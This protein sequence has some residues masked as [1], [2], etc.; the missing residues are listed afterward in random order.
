MDQ[1]RVPRG[2]SSGAQFAQRHRSEPGVSL[3]AAEWPSIAYE[4]KQ[5]EAQH[6]PAQSRRQRLRARGPYQAAIVP[7]IANANPAIS[8]QAAALVEE[9]TIE[10]VRF[11]RDLGDDTAPFAALLLRSESAASSQIEN[12]TVG[13]KRIALAQLGDRSSSNA[14]LA[15]SNIS[16]MVAA[17]DLADNLDET[18][19]LAMHRALMAGSEPEMAGRY[20]TEAVWIGGNSPHAAMFVPPSHERVPQDMEDLISFMQRDDIPALTQAAIAHA[21]FETIHPFPDGN[22]RTGRA[23]VGSML[24]NKGV[25]EK[26]TIPVSSGLLTD[27]KAYFDA[28]GAFREGQ[29]E[30]IVEMF[31]ES[32]FR[33][34]ANGRQLAEDIRIIRQEIY[35]GFGRTPGEGLKW[36]IELIV[37]EPAITAQMLSD[38]AGQSS[39]AAYRNIDRL[40]QLGALKLSGHINGHRVWVA[41]KV[42]EALDNFASRAGRRAR[43]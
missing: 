29:I 43:G 5:W 42:I 10:T 28:L 8:G 32:T 30:P 9:A 40:E 24:R 34:T 2:I 7:N 16:A 21:Q 38:T 26:V 25:T 15:A 35:T 23:L 1:P 6:D 18:N 12:L 11:D 19:I 33:A 3:P 27:T 36:A 20:R 4:E 41:P 17:V 22:G 37:R 31:A 39:S 13:A 14:A